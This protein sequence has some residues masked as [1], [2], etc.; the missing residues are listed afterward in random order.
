MRLFCVAC[1]MYGRWMPVIGCDCTALH[2]TGPL[3]FF[4]AAA[5]QVEGAASADGRGPSIWDTFSHLPGKVRNNETGDVS[6]DG[7]HHML[8]DVD[9]LYS[10]GMRVRMHV[11]ENRQ[12]NRSQI[13]R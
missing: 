6:A 11:L 10:Y 12:T 2:C 8:Q 9:L 4:I 7:Y 5:Y 1:T 13:V 3:P